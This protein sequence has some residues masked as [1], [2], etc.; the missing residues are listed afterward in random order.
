MDENAYILGSKLYVAVRIL[1]DRLCEISNT[2]SERSKA[3]EPDAKKEGSVLHT[4]TK[5][6]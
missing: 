4:L 2:R 5:L 3:D 1:L 6:V